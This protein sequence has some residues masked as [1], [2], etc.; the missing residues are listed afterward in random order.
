MLA[1]DYLVEL[2]TVLARNPLSMDD[3]SDASD[4]IKTIEA[5]PMTK[6]QQSQLKTFKQL[7]EKEKLETLFGCPKEHAGRSIQWLQSKNRLSLLMNSRQQLI[8]SEGIA[9]HTIDELAKQEDTIVRATKNTQQTNGNL[10]WASK[11]AT[12]MNSILR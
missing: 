12:K 4:L 10:G 5:C 7:L 11:L 6:D 8:E 2:S 9:Q 1:V 3:I